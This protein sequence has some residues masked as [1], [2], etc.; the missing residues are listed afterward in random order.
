MIKS[1]IYI[2]VININIKLPVKNKMKN[3]MQIFWSRTTKNESN[4]FRVP[5][6]IRRLSPQNICVAKWQKITF[7]FFNIL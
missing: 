5:F 2:N 6:V 1:L 7:S 3:K 4:K